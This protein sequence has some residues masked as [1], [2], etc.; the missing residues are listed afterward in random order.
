[1]VGALAVPNTALS[2]PESAAAA[3]SVRIPSPCLCRK[4]N[5]QQLIV[6]RDYSW[7]ELAGTFMCAPNYFSVAG[8]MLSRPRQNALL[9]ITHP[10]G[11]RSFDYEDYW[12]G[13]DLIYT[14]RGQV[15]DQRSEGQNREL[16]DNSRVNYAFESS[17]GRQLRFLGAANC[18]A[19]WE[20]VGPDRSG[21]QRRILRY[22]LRFDSRPADT[23]SSRPDPAQGQAV[24]AAP[25][26][27]GR[28]FDPN[29]APGN[30]RSFEQRATPEETAAL[31]EKA[32]RDHHSLLVRLHDELVARG[33]NRIREVP[34]AT[35]LSAFNATGQRILFEAKTVG[36]RS[37][38]TRTRSALSQLLEYR[39]FFGW[40]EDKLCLVTNHPISDARIRFL[41][42]HGVA[43][44]YDEGN[45]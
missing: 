27:R 2:V 5:P 18:I 10:G 17:G 14:G 12:D 32:N 37:D 42:A 29:R 33:W 7:D 13:D 36:A 11:G 8:G 20:A 26:R 16:A 23:W 4:R 28:D 34:G 9:L 22:R 38:V 41:E 31:Q 24:R 6:G 40:P 3:R 15:G 21:R 19:T 44:A 25:H 1:M 45:G 43:A 30:Y 35:D 39:F